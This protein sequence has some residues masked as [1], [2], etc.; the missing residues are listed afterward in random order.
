MSEQ[1]RRMS[2]TSKTKAEQGTLLRSFSNMVDHLVRENV[3]DPAAARDIVQMWHLDTFATH[4]VDALV[5][6]YGEFVIEVLS[7]HLPLHHNNLV[8]DLTQQDCP[9]LLGRAMVHYV[10]TIPS[11]G[12]LAD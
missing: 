6:L 9:P 7:Q 12:L 10:L 11:A 5:Q 1:I 2:N 8:Y 4:D 3:R